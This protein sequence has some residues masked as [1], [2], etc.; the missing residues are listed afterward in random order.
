LLLFAFIGKSS[1]MSTLPSAETLQSHVLN[2]LASSPDGSIPDTRQL[3]Y[4]GAK[5]GSGEEQ[6]V[7]KGVLDSLASKE[8]SRHSIR[9]KGNASRWPMR[10]D[11]YQLGLSELSLMMRGQM[12]SYTQITTTTQSLTDEGSSIATSGSH[13]YRV[14]Q[15]LPKKG[16][17]DAVRIPELRVSLAA[18][19]ASSLWS[20]S[21]LE[22][23]E[24][25]QRIV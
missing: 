17:G 18:S 12:I 22:S 2:A 13:E 24:C 6:A 11:G 25:K 19:R 10:N 21:G 16:E 20:P 1:A 5:L 14:W 7:L 4:S 9:R 3:E 8:V 23:R 15:A